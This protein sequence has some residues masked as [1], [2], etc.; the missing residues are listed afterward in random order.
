MCQFDTM[1][2]FKP[3]LDKHLLYYCFVLL[4]FASVGSILQIAGGNWDVTSHLLLKPE[5]FFTPSH[6]IMYGGILL[7][8][9]A[10]LVAAC[11][12]Y[13]YK[14][15][16]HDPISLS[17]KF[18]IIGSVLSI[19]SGPSDFIWHEVFGVDGFLSPTHLMLITGMLIN[20]IG[21][22][23]GLTRLSSLQKDR[24]FYIVNRMFLVIGLIALWLNLIS[25]I[26]IFSLPISSGDVFNFNLHPVLESLIAL[27]F[28]PL[29][30]AFMILFT[31][32]TIKNFGYISLVGIGVI[33]IT[34]ISNILPSEELSIFLPYYLLSV[35]P[36]IL[37][38][39]VVYDKLPFTEGKSRSKNKILFATVISA[40]LFYVIGYPMLPLALGNYL[41]PLNL[42]DME[43]S[44]LVDIIPVF[45]NS[46]SIVFPLTLT[47]GVL[48]GLGSGLIYEHIQK[49]IRN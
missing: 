46:F 33:I 35:I 1:S 49:Y 42:S 23:L 34:S 36:F 41:M 9:I 38:D 6:T 20:T 29:I 28:L 11:V 5:T 31:T 4:G 27:I 15:I 13:K 26:Y 10:A 16:K 47:I 43:F 19:V 32:N 39:F 25:Y 21:T 37:I 24:S 44:T 22:V 40:S 18:L 2:M 17:F 48:V 30:N 3:F 12:L 7:L 45:E 14:Q 8:S